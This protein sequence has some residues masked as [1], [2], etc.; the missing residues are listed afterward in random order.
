[1]NTEDKDCSELLSLYETLTPSE[2]E[3][4]LKFAQE[5]KAQRTQSDNQ[6]YNRPLGGCEINL[7]SVITNSLTFDI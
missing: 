1:M 3:A 4:V 6:K 5:L 2:A 7:Y